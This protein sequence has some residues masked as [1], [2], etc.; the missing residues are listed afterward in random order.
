MHTEVL[1][2]IR[3]LEWMIQEQLKLNGRSLPL[4]PIHETSSHAFDVTLLHIVHVTRNGLGC[5]QG[6][7]V[8]VGLPEGNDA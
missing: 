5:V 8:A 3:L 7:T 4:D 1:M 2:A 6:Q